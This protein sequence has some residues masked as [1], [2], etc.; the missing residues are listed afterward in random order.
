MKYIFGSWL[1]ES[2]YE[3][4]SREHFEVLPE[5]YQPMN[6]KAREEVWIPIKA[7]L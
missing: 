6:P 7:K 4:D 1:P 5:T 2:E 3:L